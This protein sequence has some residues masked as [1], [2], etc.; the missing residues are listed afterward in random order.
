[1]VL[2]LS[3]LHVNTFHMS[4]QRI[5]TMRQLQEVV[6]LARTEGTDLPLTT[7]AVCIAEGLGDTHE[8]EIII[9]KLEEYI[10]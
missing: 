3:K 7:I 9:R 8:V 5:N 10:S 6:K 4:E 2:A 1:M